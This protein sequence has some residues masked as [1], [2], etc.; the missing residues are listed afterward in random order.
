[1]VDISIVLPA[2]NEEEILERTV[3]ALRTGLENFPMTW[4]ILIVENGSTDATLNIATDLS[5]S[6]PEVSVC[7]L[8]EPDYGAA[9]AEGFRRSHGR[10]VVNFDVDYY[11]LGFLDA[12]IKL[13][14]DHAASIVV[15]SKR[16][17]GSDDRR[18]L[19]RR[20]L[21]ACFTAVLV[22]GFKLPVSDAHGMKLL[23]R[24]ELAALVDTCE[25]T[26]SLFDV[27]LILRADRAGLLVLELPVKVDEQRRP[28]SSVLRRTFQV[29]KDLNRLRRAL[30][31]AK[32]A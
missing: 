4:Q 6:L 11:D 26:Q 29:L 2:Y 32:A 15:A 14:N 16:A 27:E 21:T 7:T 30:Q 5:T 28:R 9:L 20:I 18:P 19:L 17:E 8:M 3:T 1:M 22:R 24:D 31:R 13:S 10:Y 23:K 12:A 25:M